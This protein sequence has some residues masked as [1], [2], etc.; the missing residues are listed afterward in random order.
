MKNFIMAMLSFGFTS[1]DL[2]AQ[3]IPTVEEV[4]NFFM[5]QQM[6]ITSREGG[7]IY[8]T[9][10]FLEIHYCPQGYG[11]Y[12]RSSKQTVMGN[13]QTNNWQEFG[14]W[15]VI[16]QNGL[17][18]LFYTVNSTGAQNFVPVYKLN[19]GSFSIGEGYTIVHQG[20]AI[21]N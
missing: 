16:E 17:V 15:K 4:N 13:Y 5:N 2:N 10:Y 18:G 7:P 12:G 14:T 9:F 3:N 20:Q 1:S 11:L 19:D 21:C 6:L 8:G